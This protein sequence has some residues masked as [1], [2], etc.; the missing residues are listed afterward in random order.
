MQLEMMRQGKDPNDVGNRVDAGEA[1]IAFSVLDI[2]GGGRISLRE[3]QRFLAGDAEYFNECSFN[4]ADVGIIWEC[5]SPGL[6][7]VKAVESMSPADYDPHCSAG[8]KL[9]SFNDK[10]TEVTHIPK[11]KEMDD[12][13][14]R[15]ETLR[16]LEH[17]VK[18]GK[19]DGNFV[20]KFL[21]PKYF[22]NAYNNILDFEIEKIGKKSIEITPGAYNS[23][24]DLLLHLQTKFRQCH[25]KLGKF[26]VTLNR[27]NLMFTFDTCGPEI[28]FLWLTGE[29]K[30]EKA[31]PVLGFINEDTD[32]D[33]Q[34]SGK[35]LSLDLDMMI[36]ADQVKIFTYELVQE[37]DK[38]FNGFIE[39]D[40]FQE[41]YDKYLSSSKKKE[42]LVERVVERFLSTAQKEERKEK[43]IE[44]KKRNKRMKAQL[45]T[46][47]KQR[48]IA[49]KQAEKRKGTMKRDA[50]GVLRSHHQNEAD[51]NYVPPKPRTPPPPRE[52]TASE[53]EQDKEREKEKAKKKK[54]MEKAKKK[55]QDLEDQIK[56][57]EE[58]AEKTK[59]WQ[60]KQHKMQLAMLGLE[61]LAEDAVTQE[62]HPAC[63]G[64]I[65]KKITKNN[66]EHISPM[67]FSTQHMKLGEAK[68]AA[69]MKL[70][71]DYGSYKKKKHGAIYQSENDKCKQMPAAPITT[72]AV[73]QRHKTFGERYDNHEVVNPAFYGQ[74]TLKNDK[75]NPELLSPVFL[76]YILYKKPVQKKDAGEDKAKL[77]AKKEA[78]TCPICYVHKEG[79]PLCWDF[80]EDYVFSDYAYEGPKREKEESDS[81][82]DEDKPEIHTS[83]VNMTS[84]KL[85][86]SVNQ[87]WLTL[88]I[89]TVPC[90]Q[91]VKM[92]VERKWTV[93]DLYENFR[94]ASMYGR[95]RDCFLFLPTEN[96]VFSFENED[97]PETDTTNAGE[98]GRVPLARNNFS[99][100]NATLCM[101]HFQFFSELTTGINIRGYL[102]Q[103]LQLSKH[104]NTSII[105]FVD[106][107]PKDLPGNDQVQAQLSDLLNN[108]IE[109][110]TK[111]AQ[112]D[113]DADNAEISS[114]IKFKVDEL[115]E[116][117]LIERK[118]KAHELWL[119]REERRKKERN[120]RNEEFNKTYKE[121]LKKQKEQKKKL[122]EEERQK[123]SIVGKA[124]AGMGGLFGG[125]LPG[126][127]FGRPFSREKSARDSS[128]DGGGGGEGK[129]G[130]EKK[131]GG[132]VSPV[133]EM[134]KNLPKVMPSE[135]S[136]RSELPNVQ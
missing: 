68:T 57:Q 62:Y 84:I 73:K 67:Y 110:A 117:L 81:E 4:Q 126:L 38:G 78:E 49:K 66:S 22:F 13:K 71:K 44:K 63:T 127:K 30:N 45:K 51:P 131:E 113:L 7:F 109:Q 132:R 14:R 120:E 69:G 102:E 129:G 53:I 133:G 46:R 128:A 58:E 29:H 116:K 65:M 48:A 134:V 75:F 70:G 94:S 55:A 123:N 104:P 12:V 93:A 91:I 96:G 43:M 80:P 97:L 83:L 3:L 76:G 17:L 90:G 100:N 52:K 135:G 19:K 34:F 2:D 136:E 114:K 28:R 64:F 24:E 82:E 89:K 36:T 115:K 33:D 125:K 56:K 31:G 42:K 11:Y 106:A 26:K 77:K 32:W 119:M 5:N 40:E 41:L 86:R 87:H 21:E 27:D 6:C 39:F 95:S 107:I 54:Q 103:N 59:L 1:Y 118:K 122:D 101:L 105:P 9:L 108:T 23:H 79:C 92:Q 85:Y 112:E 72:G 10:N 130:E 35:P 15:E 60:E 61:S 16:W 20:Y 50:D 88:F 98:T 124:K 8:L 99:R 18:D 74:M 121:I 47:E 111:I 25:P 37:F